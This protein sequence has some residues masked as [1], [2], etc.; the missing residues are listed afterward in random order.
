M[1]I[2]IYLY[3]Y[4]SLSIYI[5]TYV[6]YDLISWGQSGIELTMIEQRNMGIE[7]TMGY[8]WIEWGI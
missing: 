7:L 3:L 4:L 1:S 8:M 5:H 6:F 2:S